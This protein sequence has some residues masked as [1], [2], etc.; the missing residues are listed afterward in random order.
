MGDSFSFLHYTRFLPLESGTYSPVC[1]YNSS[2]L[3]RPCLTS[4]MMLKVSGRADSASTEAA[5][6]AATAL[7]NLLLDRAAQRL[8]TDMQGV[9]T[10]SRLLSLANWILAARAAGMTALIMVC[11]C[12]EHVLHETYSVYSG[13]LHC[14]AVTLQTATKLSFRVWQ[15]LLATD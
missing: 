3:G 9:A 8:V 4:T 10:V 13:S 15:A 2:C 6:A 14:V 5:L 12:S 7:Q 1:V 11:I